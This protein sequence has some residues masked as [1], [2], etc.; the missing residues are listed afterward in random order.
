MGWMKFTKIFVLALIFGQINQCF[1][2]TDGQKAQKQ[3]DQTL[4]GGPHYAAPQ[5]RAPK[6]QSKPRPK[7]VLS[8]SRLMPRAPGGGVSYD[9]SSRPK[10][11]VGGNPSNG[12]PTKTVGDVRSL[13]LL[14]R[15]DAVPPPLPPVPS[16]FA[17]TVPSFRGGDTVASVNPALTRS[18]SVPDQGFVVSPPPTAV[19]E[20]PSAPSTDFL[21]PPSD[22]TGQPR[23]MS[24]ARRLQRDRALQQ[25]S[26]QQATP[27]PLTTDLLRQLDELTGSPVLKDKSL[28]DDWQSLPGAVSSDLRT[29]DRQVDDLAALHSVVQLDPKT[30]FESVPRYFSSKGGAGNNDLANAMAVVKK[31]QNQFS[32]LEPIRPLLGDQQDSMQQKLAIM[33]QQS[34]S[35]QLKKRIE[36]AILS[37]NF[38]RARDN[39]DTK[40]MDFY[41]KKLKTFDGENPKIKKTTDDFNPFY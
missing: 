2:T 5:N 27:A 8:S 40:G 24:T 39:G 36:R 37:A 3:M 12:Q 10:T 15:S 4:G 20:R 1:A 7:T 29:L 17:A 13:M 41:S 19:I 31:L 16:A 22:Q 32:A 11:R 21:Q 23:P 28:E 33:Q 14:K 9:T 25:A 18:V 35:D 34:E 26:S 30:E 38:Y 6:P